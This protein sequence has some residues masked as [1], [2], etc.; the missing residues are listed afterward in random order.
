MDT[1]VA[2]D[3]AR[4]ERLI[5]S[6]E[7]LYQRIMETQ[8]PAPPTA[9][10]IDDELDTEDPR[11]ATECDPISKQFQDCANAVARL[12]SAIEEASAAWRNS[13]HF[14]VAEVW[15]TLLPVQSIVSA[16]YACGT[17]P[18][19][20]ML[21]MSS[22]P[23]PVMRHALQQILGQGRPVAQCYQPAHT[24]RQ[25]GNISSSIPTQRVILNPAAVRAMTTYVAN[26]LQSQIRL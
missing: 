16:M 8:P 7:D 21:P 5:T 23:P 13:Q 4:I 6:N 24:C 3:S 17:A 1:G 2:N 25:I 20:N 15:N 26:G 18:I 22:A 19:D 12:S 10:P 14:Q 11:N 9:R